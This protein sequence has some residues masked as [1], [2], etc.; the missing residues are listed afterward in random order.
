M[1]F[2][3]PT[4]PSLFFIISLLIFFLLKRRS[5]SL[6]IQCDSNFTNPNPFNHRHRQDLSFVLSKI[7]PNHL[8]MNHSK[9]HQ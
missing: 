5:F 4:V 1:P 2:S 8:I 7:K 6:Y 3:R 9:R